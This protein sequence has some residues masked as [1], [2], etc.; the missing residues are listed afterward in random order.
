M[1]PLAY[2]LIVAGGGT[3]GSAA[4]IAAARRGHN[5]LLVEEQNCLGGTST[6]TMSCPRRNRAP[7]RRVTHH[8]GNTWMRSAITHQ[9][10]TAGHAVNTNTRKF[11]RR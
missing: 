6:A 9:Q 10:S 4:A 8:P 1:P 5:V 7:A 11:D 3:A 2:D